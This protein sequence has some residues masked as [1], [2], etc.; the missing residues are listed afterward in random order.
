MNI[1]IETWITLV[2]YAIGI[3]IGYVN[4]RNKV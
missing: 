1:A 4:L 3:V 2:V